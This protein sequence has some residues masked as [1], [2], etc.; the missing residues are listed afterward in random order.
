MKISFHLKIDLIMVY[1]QKLEVD[2]H[3]WEVEH[4]CSDKRL[5]GNTDVN[6]TCL[7]LNRGLI[8]IM[9]ALFTMNENDTLAFLRFSGVCFFTSPEMFSKVSLVKQVYLIPTEGGGALPP[10]KFFFCITWKYWSRLFKML[11]FLTYI[12]PSL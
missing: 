4:C 6:Q 2:L 5:K 3:G 9:F 10:L 1:S 12:C 7:Y 11:T 8:K